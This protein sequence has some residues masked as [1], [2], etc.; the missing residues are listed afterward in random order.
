MNH[1]QTISNLLNIFNYWI[2][3]YL[4]LD[5]D[6]FPNDAIAKNRNPW[7]VR[8]YCSLF[9]GTGHSLWEITIMPLIK[10]YNSDLSTYGLE[11]HSTFKSVCNTEASWRG[12]FGHLIRT[13]SAESCFFLQDLRRRSIVPTNGIHE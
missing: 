5:K 4:C 6:W 7:T 3:L 2:Q 9:I 12:T 11:S 8:K 13:A 10:D 1:K